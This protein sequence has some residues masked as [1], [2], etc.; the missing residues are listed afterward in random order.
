MDSFSVKDGFLVIGTTNFLSSLDPAFVRSGRFDRILGLNYPPKQ[1]R[2]A[3]LKLHIQKKGNFF[4]FKLP[5]N[6]FGLKTKDLSPADLAKIVN[7]SSLYLVNQLNRLKPD[8]DQDPKG[9]SFL[10]RDSKMGSHQVNFIFNTLGLFV[11]IPKSLFDF[12]PGLTHTSQSLR[13]GFVKI[14]ESK[15]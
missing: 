15:K 11:N 7:E 1:T 4:D 13:E 5:W 3:I 10:R 6:I 12:K 8:L 9:S 14:L 2:I